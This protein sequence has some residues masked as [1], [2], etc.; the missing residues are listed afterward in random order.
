MIIVSA[1]LA[2]LNTRYDGGNQAD[3]RVI[4][5]LKAGMACPVCPEQL[6]GLPT[7]RPKAE[8]Q[9]GNG[10]DVL[11]KKAVVLAEDG[12]DLTEQFIRGASEVLKLA[13][14][15]NI[16]EAIL[17]DGSPS[18]GVTYIK[19]KGEEI[20]GMGVLTALFSLN[21]LKVRSNDSL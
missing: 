16:E 5:L 11:S 4:A 1:C 2:G 15:M 8:I 7:P 3:E 13:G 6:G 19:R 21:G 20:V 18:C 9:D 10:H 17:K 14:S 12:T